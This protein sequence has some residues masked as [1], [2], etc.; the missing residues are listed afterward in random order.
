MILYSKQIITKNEIKDG[1]L[2]IE[3]GKIQRIADASEKLTA[4]AAWRSLRPW[5]AAGSRSG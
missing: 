5:A 3:N 4:E 2:I 1:Y